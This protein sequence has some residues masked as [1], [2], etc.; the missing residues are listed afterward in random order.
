M[1]N[2]LSVKRRRSAGFTLIELLVVIAIIAI[3]IGLLLPAVQKVREAAA[4]SSCS[5]NLRQ[6]GIGLHN[7]HDVNTKCPPLMGR[8][9]QL[10]G[11]Q[12]TL[13]FWLLPYIEQDNLAKSCATGNTYDPLNLPA[14]NEACTHPVKTYLCPADPSL[15]A[16][17]QTSIGQ[18]TG[19]TPSG[20]IPAATSYAA[21]GLA[22][23]VIDTNTGLA[24]NG[25]NGGEFYA[26]IPRTFTDGTS[27]TVIFAEK[28]AYCAVGNANNTGSLWYRNNWT[29]TWG[30]YYNVR[31]GGPTFTFQVQ[32]SPIPTNCEYRLPST[33]HPG[34]MI[35]CMGDASVRT[36]S[37][38]VSALTWWQA[39]TPNGNE[40]LANDWL[41]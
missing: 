7:C 3:L 11:N 39:N 16:N 1:S 13:Q 32:P 9:P 23:A 12:E 4:R 41:P 2:L 5:N 38:G 8:F 36:V 15:N 37:R 19:T 10:I 6:M 26:G 22:F 40:V 28:Y 14:G 25:G 35:V 21:N 30:P 17:G 33:P 34:G 31:L 24:N 20:L 29:S 27:N 18:P